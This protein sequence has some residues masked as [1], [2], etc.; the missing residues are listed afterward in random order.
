MKTEGGRR[1]GCRSVEEE[2]LLSG[3]W[4]EGSERVLLFLEP[5]AASMQLD[6]NKIQLRKKQQV[7]LRN[8]V[9]DHPSWR[10]KCVRPMA[11]FDKCLIFLCYRRYFSLLVVSLVSTRSSCYSHLGY[12]RLLVSRRPKLQPS[13]LTPNIQATREGKNSSDLFL[14][15]FCL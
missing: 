9:S 13:R 15:H 1:K 10:N 3:N 5:A 4:R 14:F 7:N 11:K 6:K 2:H 12:S 8:M